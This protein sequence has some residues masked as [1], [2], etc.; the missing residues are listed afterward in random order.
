MP[1]LLL[2]KP[3]GASVEAGASGEEEAERETVK[4]AR[5]RLRK[6]TTIRSRMGRSPFF[7][8]SSTCSVQDSK[9]R[10]R[11]VLARLPVGTRLF[12]DIFSPAVLEVNC[13]LLHYLSPAPPRNSGFLFG[14]LKLLLGECTI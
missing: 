6:V 14:D 8:R 3:V 1:L 10:V 4:V 2:S 5:A 9:A 13:K 7:F 12:Q 11:R